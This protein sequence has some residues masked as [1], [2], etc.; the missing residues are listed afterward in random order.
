MIRI[1]SSQLSSLD[2]QLLSNCIEQRLNKIKFETFTFDADIIEDAK[3]NIYVR[4]VP[5]KNIRDRDRKS[6]V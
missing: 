6:V 1:N 4:Y 5:K 2:S 3:G